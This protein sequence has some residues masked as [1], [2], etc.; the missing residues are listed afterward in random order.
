VPEVLRTKVSVFVELYKTTAEIK[1]QAERLRQSEERFRL[2]MEGVKDYAI[3]MLDAQGR[4]A[5]WNAGAQ[6]ITGYRAA[7]IISQHVSRFYPA[8]DVKRGKPEH[9]LQVTAAEG[10]LE[11]EGWR[12]RKDGSRYWANVILTALRDEHGNPRGFATVIRD[13]TARKQ[14]EKEILEISDREQRRIGQDLHDD[15]CQR[16]AGIEFMSQ[17]LEQNLAA[18]SRPETTAAAEITQLVREAIARTRDL[19]RGLS[20][21]LLESDGLAS[22]LQELAMN[23]EKLFRISCQFQCDSS[24]LI[25]DNAVATHLYRIA[26]EAVSNAVKHGKA[27]QVVIRLAKAN[28]RV[29]LTITNDGLGFPKAAHKTKGMG[30]RIMQYRAGMIGGSLTVQREGAAGTNVT[31]SLSV[32]GDKNTATKKS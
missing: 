20:P 19:A 29:V 8:E 10:W 11:D 5:S 3:Y 13:I 14:L 21:V 6:Q 4:V 12:V 26:Q 25:Q 27:R 31:C 17:V 2:L 32:L 23:N 18:K 7:E 15:L 24:V 1:R 9:D 30:L 28:D 22:A 16:L